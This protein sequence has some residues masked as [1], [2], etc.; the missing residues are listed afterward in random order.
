[1]LVESQAALRR[2]P[3]HRKRQVLILSAG[4][5]FAA[6]LE[7]AGYAVSVIAAEDARQGLAQFAARHKPTRLISME[8]AEYAP[9]RWQHGGLEEDLRV[10]ATLLP[11]TMFLLGRYDP[12]PDRRPDQRVVMETFYR[13]MRKRFGLLMEPDGSRPAGPGI[14]TRRTASRCLG[15]WTLPRS[16]ASSRTTSR[17][18]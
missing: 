8:A 12:K 1:M 9:R 13:G 3:Y 17:G 10:P 2:L 5:H 14:T 15:R 6:R 4:R 7:E 11:N 16:R 18:R